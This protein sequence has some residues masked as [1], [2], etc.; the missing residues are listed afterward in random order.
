ML[1]EVSTCND[2]NVDNR[3]HS[4]SGRFPTIEEDVEPSHLIF[5]DYAKYIRF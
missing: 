5:K 3:F 1:F 4:S 2:D